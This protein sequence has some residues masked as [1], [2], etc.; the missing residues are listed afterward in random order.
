MI[1]AD[2]LMKTSPTDVILYIAPH[3][4]G[5]IGCRDKQSDCYSR[6]LREKRRD[7]NEKDVIKEEED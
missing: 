1:T 7:K 4:T 5:F 2:V 3:A 6:Y